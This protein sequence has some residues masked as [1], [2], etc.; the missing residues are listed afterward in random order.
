MEDAPP[1]RGIDGL[2]Q[3]LLDLIEVF[4]IG[5]SAPKLVPN[6]IKRFRNNCS[7]AEL[8]FW[9]WRLEGINI[10]AVG[11]GMVCSQNCW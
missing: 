2:F 9:F 10:F 5:L 1:I 8:F 6:D 7:A 4:K 11:N 3:V